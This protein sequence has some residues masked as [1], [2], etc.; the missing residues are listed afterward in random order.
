[1]RIRTKRNYFYKS[2][3]QHILNR[4]VKMTIMFFA[5][6]CRQYIG[7]CLVFLCVVYQPWITRENFMI[8]M[9]QLLGPRQICLLVYKVL[10]KHRYLNKRPSLEIERA[11]PLNE[12]PTW[13]LTCKWVPWVLFW[14]NMV[15]YLLHIT[16]RS[17]NHNLH[18]FKS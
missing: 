2:G 9:C 5:Q 1:M 18:S 10:P 14:G 7:S 11:L 8:F 12:C 16:Y 4:K 3:Q 15:C 17:R 6:F 13:G